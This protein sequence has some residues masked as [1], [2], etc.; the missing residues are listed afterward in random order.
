MAERSRTRRKMLSFIIFCSQ[1]LTTSVCIRNLHEH[2]M[3]GSGAGFKFKS[4]HSTSKR[5]LPQFGK[6]P[7]MVFTSSN[8]I[9]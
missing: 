5:S 4:K 9:V 2:G 6:S 8:P 3:G 7:S 1:F